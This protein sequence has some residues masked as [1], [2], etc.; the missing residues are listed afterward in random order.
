MRISIIAFTANG[1][2]TALRIKEALEGDDVSVQCKTAH[3]VEGV[4]RI[5]T[6]SDEWTRQRFEDSDALVFVGATG[7]A[8][9]LIV[10]YVMSKD[11]DPAVV[12]VDEHGKFTIAL[13]SGHIGGCNKL[14]NRIAAGIGSTPVVT[15]ATDING[16][17]SVDVFATENSLRITNL[18]KAQITS[19]KVLEDKFVGF[20][21]ELPVE[22]DLPRG[23]TL[24]E[25]GDF[26]I[27]ISR[28]PTEHPFDNTFN[29]VP[30]DISVGVG[31]KR[32]TDPAKMLA[33]VK[34]ILEEDGIAPERVGSISSVDLKSDERAVLEL[35]PEFKCP[36]M[37]FSAEE[38]MSLEG[39]FSSSNF[40]RS[41]TA[42]DCVCERSAVKA[43]GGTIVRRKTASDGMTVAL[44]QTDLQLRF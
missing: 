4:E 10:P 43:R 11:V 28:D 29:L 1:C 38:L 44:C 41:V 32:G 18:H 20:S 35:A 7:I 27:R 12:C 42:V 19:S 26:G 23:L 30:M 21:S 8:V 36:V 6:T 34:K 5:K 17:F 25:S 22:G 13:L 9:R 39:K 15:T 14:A 16:K 24:A 40:V 37:F 3:E 33:F 31:C 2:R